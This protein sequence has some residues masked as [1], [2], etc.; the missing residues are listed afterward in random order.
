MGSPTTGSPTGPLSPLRV[1]SMYSLATVRTVCGQ[2][3]LCSVG[4]GNT[5]KVSKSNHSFLG[6][7]SPDLRL[8]SEAS[9]RWSGVW[10]PSGASCA[11]WSLD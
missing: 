9:L 10:E 7:T 11:G 5:E 3:E 2:F 4:T 8:P 6:L 1:G